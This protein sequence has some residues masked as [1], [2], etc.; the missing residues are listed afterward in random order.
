MRS[1]AAKRR[2]QLLSLPTDL[3]PSL[4][5]FTSDVD[6]ARIA[7]SSKRARSTLTHAVW[8][9]ILRSNHGGLRIAAG[10]DGLRVARHLWAVRGHSSD[11]VSP[12]PSIDGFFALATNC[13][14]APYAEQSYWADGLFRR[15]TW[16]MYSTK[17]TGAPVLAVAAFLA[18]GDFNEEPLSVRSFLL[19]HT[20]TNASGSHR[21][22]L[23]RHST[24]SASLA[25]VFLDIWG[26]M[27]VD[28][29]EGY[30]DNE[31]TRMILERC[32]VI[33][34]RCE[35]A[36][37]DQEERSGLDAT[38]FE[39]RGDGITADPRIEG[40]IGQ[41]PASTP[42]AIATG[43][44]VRRSMECTCPGRAGIIFGLRRLPRVADVDADSHMQRLVTAAAPAVRALVNDDGR[45]ADLT[46]DAKDDL[47][48][49]LGGTRPVQLPVYDYT[50]GPRGDELGVCYQ[51][52]GGD[53]DADPCVKSSVHWNTL[54]WPRPGLH[55]AAGAP[56]A[57]GA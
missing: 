3:L 11:P 37:V 14:P 33:R 52:L 20:E 8:S 15:E 23:N 1:N 27:G 17:Q 40:I 26:S 16:R 28:E 31:E 45:A 10:D 25:A 49:R 53:E 41:F 54:R 7:I 30:H 42:M 44:V 5:A 47:G 43:V 34:R 4:G 13:A 19:D 9:A 51:L 6:A 55:Q 32:A 38:V 18:I 12:D 57:G 35:A 46:R 50:S 39:D 24:T 36:G 21:L 2:P 22:D 48:R 29:A 56:P